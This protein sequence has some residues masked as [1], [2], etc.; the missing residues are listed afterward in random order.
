MNKDNFIEILQRDSPDKVIKYIHSKGKRKK[1]CPI[2]MI[3]ILKPKDI[4]ISKDNV[5]DTI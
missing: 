3:D 1:I 5:I 2:I 4:S